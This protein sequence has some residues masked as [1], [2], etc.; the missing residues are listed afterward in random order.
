VRKI[1]AQPLDTDDWH[2]WI[3]DCEKATQD[4]IVAVA[5][6][7]EASIESTLYRR[8]KIK[9]AYFFSKGAPFYGKCAYCE[10]PLS[11]FQPGD[12][13]HFRP[14]AAIT[15]EDDQKIY[16]LDDQG[17]QILDEDNNPKL[18][19]GYYWLGYDWCNLIP[20]CT[21]CN[22]PQ[23]E[24]L[25]KRSRFP[26]ADKH[27]QIPGDE[28]KE[29]PLLINPASQD[30]NDDPDKH[31]FVDDTGV[32]GFRSD[33]GKMCINIFGLNSREQLTTARRTTQESVN[34]KITNLQKT[35]M[36]LVAGDGIDSAAVYKNLISCC[37]Q[38]IS[39]WHGE[40]AY[41]MSAQTILR[42]K[43]FSLEWLYQ[44]RQDFQELLSKAEFQDIDEI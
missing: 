32:M 23:S 11:D 42:E 27:A 3:E 22:R 13:E 16:L 1:V 34:F 4:N 6:G 28:A 26:V 9:N 15:D 12:I 33:R 2:Q 20:S 21:V 8:K 39:I 35:F 17:Q 5:Q 40:E 19:P 31:L 10:H 43:K 7:G 41:T 18:H 30:E 14:K 37:D 25:G 38:L 44:K 29:K 24:N 36:K